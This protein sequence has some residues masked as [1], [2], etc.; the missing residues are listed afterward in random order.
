MCCGLRMLSSTWNLNTFFSSLSSSLSSSVLYWLFLPL[1][2]SPVSLFHY[3]QSLKRVELPNVV[4]AIVNKYCYFDPE[5]WIHEKKMDV[6]EV[7]CFA[8]SKIS[9]GLVFNKMLWDFFS[10][11]LHI[12]TI[13][14]FLLDADRASC[15]MWLILF[16]FYIA[17]FMIIAFL[18]HYI[19]WHLRQWWLL[20]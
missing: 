20:F 7:V 2:F 14:M 13:R 1:L 10:P 17:Y 8:G 9:L 4:P 12:C 11:F 16:I 5:I 18:F 6:W 19:D 15:L 3:S